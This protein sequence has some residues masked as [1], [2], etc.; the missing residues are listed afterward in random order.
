MA[1]SFRSWLIFDDCLSEGCHAAPSSGPCSSEATGHRTCDAAIATSGRFLALMTQ[2]PELASDSLVKSRFQCSSQNK[3]WSTSAILGLQL[4]V[5]WFL[6]GALPQL[7]FWT[8]NLLPLLR[9]SKII[10]ATLQPICNLS[11]W[12][13][14]IRVYPFFFTSANG[15]RSYAVRRVGPWVRSLL[16]SL[17]CVVSCKWCTNNW[18]DQQANA[19]N[20]PCFFPKSV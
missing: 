9:T 12:R 20:E 8:V 7:I 4:L 18:I 2:P 17:L 14:N 19:C 5:I 15:P 6:D 1:R 10:F 11:H 13:Q 16:A 3:T